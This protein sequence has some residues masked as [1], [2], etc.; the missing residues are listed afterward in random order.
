LTPHGYK[1]LQN[2]GAYD[3]ASLTSEGL[4]SQNTCADAATTTIW[5]DTDQRTLA[6]G[7]AL[8]EGLFPTCAPQVHSLAE[9]ENDPLFHPSLDALPA[10]ITAAALTELKQR[11]AAQTVSSDDPLLHTLQNLLNGCAPHSSCTP[12]QAPHNT[13]F[14]IPP[15]VVGGK[16]DH[17]ADLQG[18]LPL[19]STFS[20][21][22][23]LEYSEGM[24]VSDVGWGNVNEAQLRSLI[25][26]HTRYFDL[27]H[28]T[29]A[30]ARLGSA[31]MLQQIS[32]TLK[33]AVEGRPTAGA[34][35]PLQSKLVVLV[36]HDT[37]LAGV[38]ALLG[39]HW[40][41]DGRTDDTSPGTELTFE[42]WQSPSGEYFVRTILRQ[43]TLQ[44]MRSLQPLTLTKPPAQTALKLQGCPAKRCTWS[45]FQSLV[46]SNVP[47]H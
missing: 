3:H 10:S 34:L 28:R 29:L 19:A 31:G 44:Q 17:I 6:S 35:A 47:N 14:E 21:D 27:M 22:L 23:L 33:Q 9:G 13:L 15:A 25:A 42:L 30:L 38:A 36:G 16:G 40:T 5:A 46:Q 2:F 1:L 43:Q 32:D 20:E 45:A 41:L 37:N 7:H 18:P 24:P 39:I 8:A 4:F 11:Y 26:L 12:Q